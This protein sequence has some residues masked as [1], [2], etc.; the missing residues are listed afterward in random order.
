M[1]KKK[2][3]MV[4]WSCQFDESVDWIIPFNQP[5]QLA[6]KRMNQA[7]YSDGDN[8]SKQLNFH[9]S[10]LIQANSN[11]EKESRINWVSALGSLQ[12]LVQ[13]DCFDA[14]Q[15]SLQSRRFQ[16]N[17]SAQMVV[18]KEAK[19]SPSDSGESSIN[20]SQRLDNTFVAM[21]QPLI[22]IHREC[23]A[24]NPSAEAPHPRKTIKGEIQTDGGPHIPHQGDEF[25]RRYTVDRGIFASQTG[26]P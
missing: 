8:K 16:S 23:G 17:Q 25:S 3:L 13:S 22:L 10:F 24:Q 2:S 19:R 18:A 26:N 11:S 4:I 15:P 9:H 21:P 20:R 1:H 6:E 7:D 14:I 12:F 5:I